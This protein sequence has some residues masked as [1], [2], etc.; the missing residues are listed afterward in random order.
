MLSFKCRGAVRLLAVAFLAGGVWGSIG[1]ATA[2]AAGTITV[3]A[4]GCNYTDIQ[5]A[6]NASSSGDTIQVGAGTYTQTID[7]NQSVTIEGAG[8]GN[9]II[10]ADPGTIVNRFTL[11]PSGD[12]LTNYP[13]VYADAPEV[14][15]EDLTVDGLDDGNSVGERF[16][17]IAEYNDNLTVN[18]VHVTGI[19]DSPP[20]GDQT[21]DAIYAVND[22]STGRH[23]TITNSRISDYQKNGIT[24]D[25]NSDV[26]VD[27]SG[28][29]MR[30]QRVSTS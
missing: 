25:G 8:P 15:I 22:Q 19:S 7:V 10:D 3:C 21:G 2:S 26:T 9:T 13:I 5:S 12:D 16:E 6:V 11:A 1:V 23:V 28:N 18:D 17:G 27:I 20:S 30:H 29:T 14:T 24:V 4:S